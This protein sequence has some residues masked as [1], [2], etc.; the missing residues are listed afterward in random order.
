LAV[1]P[2]S[3]AITADDDSAAKPARKPRARRAKPVDDD[4]AIAAAE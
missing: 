3:I 2:P 4:A 1:L